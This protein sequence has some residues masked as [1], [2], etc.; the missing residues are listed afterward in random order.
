MPTITQSAA[1][2]NWTRI[3]SYSKNITRH[4]IRIHDDHDDDITSLVVICVG[5]AIMI[6]ML[7]LHKCSQDDRSRSCSNFR[8]M[9][10]DM[11]HVVNAQ[12]QISGVAGMAAVLV[13][14]KRKDTL[15]PPYEDPPSYDVAVQ[16]E[17]ELT[18]RDFKVAGPS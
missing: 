6:V 2:L 7:V 11:T 9:D 10:E 15:P 8:R 17:I 14:M 18:K 13:R 5:L 16:M 1:F 4:H 12:E 3:L